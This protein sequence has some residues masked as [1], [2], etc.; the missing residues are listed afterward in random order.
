ML[1]RTDARKALLS[2]FGREIGDESLLR[3]IDAGATLLTSGLLDSIATLRL[4]MYLE[5][6]FS[7][8]IEAQDLTAE[9]FDTVDLILDFVRGRQSP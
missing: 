7:I 6:T 4:V 3:E 5:Q 8:S 1:D 2:Q 9:N